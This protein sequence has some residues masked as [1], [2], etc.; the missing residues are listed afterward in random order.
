M[1]DRIINE[2]IRLSDLHPNG[3]VYYLA[4]ALRAAARYCPDRIQNI[5]LTRTNALGLQV[6]R[7]SYNGVMRDI[8]IDDVLPLGPDREFAGLQPAGDYYWP[9]LLEK[10][11]VKLYRGYKNLGNVS[12]S[13]AINALLRVPTVRSDFRRGRED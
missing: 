13:H 8:L 11:W 10:A 5:F 6:L 7:F 1:V 12:P 2:D 9:C 4:L 3:N